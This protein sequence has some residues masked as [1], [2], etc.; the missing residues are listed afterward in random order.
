MLYYADPW[1]D[2]PYATLYGEYCDCTFS[3]E[4]LELRIIKKNENE[5]I[6]YGYCTDVVNAYR[7]FK[8]DEF[9]FTQ[10][11]VKWEIA[12]VETETRQKKDD[13]W[14]TV[15]RYP[16]YGE[17]YL[18]SQINARPELFNTENHALRGHIDFQDS[19]LTKAVVTGENSKG[20]KLTQPEISQFEEMLDFYTFDVC[21]IDLTKDLSPILKLLEKS[22]NATKSKGNGYEYRKNSLIKLM[23]DL[24]LIVDMETPLQDILFQLAQWE[25]NNKDISHVLQKLIEVLIK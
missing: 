5:Y 10:Q 15:P 1:K 14:V 23:N 2:S 3:I 21:P 12:A 24:G 16:S 11:L 18:V 19:S 8:P 13:K 20:I 9:E 7:K 22:T 4:W 25:H 6:F 17:K